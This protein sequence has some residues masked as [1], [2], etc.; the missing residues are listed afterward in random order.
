MFNSI[1]FGVGANL[2]FP[3][4]MFPMPISKRGK[5]FLS[6]N[7]DFLSRINFYDYQTFNTS[8]G[9]EWFETNQQKRKHILKIINVEYI[10]PT[11]TENFNTR[12]LDNNLFLKNSFQKGLFI[13]QSYSYIYQSNID[14]LKKEAYYIRINGDFAPINI[15][16]SSSTFIKSDIDFKWINNLNKGNTLAVRIASGI[17]VPLTQ[18]QS[19]PYVK[20]FFVGGPNSIRA[21]RIR[22]LGPGGFV[23]S[24]TFNTIQPYQAGNIKLESSIE[25]RFDIVKAFYLEGAVFGDAGNIWTLKDDPNRK[26]PDGTNC[27]GFDGDFYKN[28]AVGAGFGIRFDFSYFIIRLDLGYKIKN[29]HKDDNTYWN[30]HSNNP[31]TWKSVFGDATY[32]LALGYPF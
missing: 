22:D 10:N 21:W 31:F 11:T 26:C 12:V 20:Q 27:S 29:P 6:A 3:Q 15:N 4:L 30:Y 16:N 13:G 32:N 9:Y 24:L 19:L 2:Y 8:Y 7:Y 1:D 23:D 28:I 17:G 14:L 18:N 5:T 25:Y